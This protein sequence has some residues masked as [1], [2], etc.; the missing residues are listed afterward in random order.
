MVRVTGIMLTT[1]QKG[2]KNSTQI[3]KIEWLIGTLSLM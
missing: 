1:S 2:Q 3:N